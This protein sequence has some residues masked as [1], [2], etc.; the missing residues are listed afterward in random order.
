MRLNSLISRIR[1]E[2]QTIGFDIG[3]RLARVAVV[4]H[5]QGEKGT[6]LALEQD[7]VP[8]GVVVD[9]EIRNVSVLMDK[10]HALLSRAMPGGL[11]GDFIVSINWT[12]GILCDRIL[13]KPVPKVPEN[14][15]ILQTAQGRSP[16]DDAGNVLDYSILDRRDDGTEAM[17][18]AAKKDGLMSWINLF[19]ALNIKLSAIDVDAFVLGNVYAASKLPSDSSTVGLP[20]P[21]DEDDDSILLLNLGYSKSYAA[22]LRNG[23][24]NTARSI[25]GGSLHDLQEQLSGPLGISPEK[26]GDLL[27]GNN[28]KDVDLDESKI[29][30]ATEFVFEEIAMKVDTALR[31]FSSSDNYKKP[32]KIIITGG[33]SNI[34]GLASFLADRLSLDTIQLNP[35]KAVQIDKERFRGIDWNAAASTYN[36]ALGL[37][38]RRF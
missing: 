31:Y 25:L 20:V 11:D 5:K 17:I 8:E 7:V 27:M 24:F 28:L 37:A 16:F 35:F 10:V 29:K 2:S 38:L 26:G 23:Y 36:V 15:L 21:G 33:G 6:L 30:F 14:E 4:G 12:S 32:S 3:H 9:N 34:V 19:Q 13:V 18:V 1:G 22:F